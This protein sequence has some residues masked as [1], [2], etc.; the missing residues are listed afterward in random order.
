MKYLFKALVEW[1]VPRRYWPLLLTGMIPF[2]PLVLQQYF[3]I[4]FKE[5]LHHW[6]FAVFS[7]VV[8]IV[9]GSLF[10]FLE[11]I[12]KRTL[13]RT[14]SIFDR[15]NIWKILYRNPIKLWLGLLLVIVGIYVVNMGYGKSRP[16]V[17]PDNK[18]VVTV[19]RFTPVSSAAIDDSDNVSH[20]IEQLLLEK[21]V[22]GAPLEVKRLNRTAEGND[23][24]EKEDAARN[25]AF[26]SY[27]YCHVVIWGE[28]R[29]DE[30]EIYVKPHITIARQP[31]NIILSERSISPRRT[32]APSNLEFKELLASDVAELVVF[33]YGLSYFAKHDWNNAIEILQHARSSEGALLRGLSFQERASGKNLRADLLASVECLQRFFPEDGPA[34]LTVGHFYAASYMGSAYARLAD[35][36]LPKDEISLLRS[37]EK[38]SR[39]ADLLSE[40]AE[41]PQQQVNVKTNLA[42]TLTAL[43]LI[44][45]GAEGQKLLGE[46]LNLLDGVANSAKDTSACTCRTMVH[47]QKIKSLYV[48]AQIAP[49]KERSTI[50]K[51]AVELCHWTV[52]SL[53][54]SKGS[55]SYRAA[56]YLFGFILRN[57]GE[58]LSGGRKTGLVFIRDKAADTQALP[59]FQQALA[60]QRAALSEVDVQTRPDEWSSVQNEIGLSL[61]SLGSI[62]QF[63]GTDYLQQAI[64]VHEAVLKVLT[65]E[66]APQE[67][68]RT[69]LYLSEALQELATYSSKDE[70]TNFEKAIRAKQFALEVFTKEAS[71]EIWA[72]EQGSLGVMLNN[73][74]LVLGK[75]STESNEVLR[76]A[77]DACRRPLEVFN[78]STHPVEWGLANC[79]LGQVLSL[80][81]NRTSSKEG[82]KYLRD[83]IDAIL[84]GQKVLT[85]EAHF[86]EWCSCQN[87]LYTAQK[88]L[89]FRGDRSRPWTATSIVICN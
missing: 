70:K 67:W 45:K 63:G 27:G 23:D 39:I 66:E 30:G 15:P 41:D 81:G 51:R 68:A 61:R 83:G 60:A 80:L 14:G 25:I 10:Y 78:E 13:P 6:T 3:S 54:N 12:P 88:T 29:K 85:K 55:G 64:S 86:Y 72:S 73:F 75:D 49:Q 4:T 20:R 32:L 46:A 57:I 28:V 76:K 33:I 44:T 48:S 37:A 74:G 79:Q 21:K 24:K 8:L 17:L 7:G 35:F 36:A 16:P 47:L 1:S 31:S 59:F 82:V 11:F 18:M 26:S 69:Q 52:D 22:Q 5:A 84:K 62:G 89:W 40:Q 56:Q 9:A 58:D 2:A 65:K 38:F 50:L 71:P 87:K 19:L 34:L 43:A 53:K 42:S 77:V